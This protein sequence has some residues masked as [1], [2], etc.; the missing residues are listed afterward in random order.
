MDTVKKVVDKV[1]TIATY[2]AIFSLVFSII[3]F[4]FFTLTS[5]NSNKKSIGILRALGAKTSDI[6]KIFYLESFLMGFFAMILSSI[7]CY[8]SVVVANKLISSNLFVNV[9]PI[10]FKPD[11][12]LILFIVLLILTTISFTI[13]IFKIT[14]TK[15]ID[16]INNK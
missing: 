13:P 15:P 12:F 16:V 4:M 10:I 14:K 5:V 8:L 1:S 11:I 9:S 3:L 7:G 6:Y 2:S